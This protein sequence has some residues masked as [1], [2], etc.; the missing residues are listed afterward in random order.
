[1][2]EL[3]RRCRLSVGV[4]AT[5]PGIGW[6]PAA[7]PGPE[8]AATAQARN[9]ALQFY[10]VR[11]SKDPDDAFAARSGRFIALRSARQSLACCLLVL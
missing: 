6:P 2:I 4:E 8:L 5:R 10:P 3:V 9:V 7:G 1:L 11:E